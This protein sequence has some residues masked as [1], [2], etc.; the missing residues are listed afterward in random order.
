MSKLKPK[1]VNQTA[2]LNL[3]HGS[4]ILYKK[5]FIQ[6]HL[7]SE[8]GTIFR[9]L[10]DETKFE[11]KD[12]VVLGKKVKQPRLLAYYATD[13][14]RGSFTYTGLR[15]IPSH[16]TPFVEQLKNSVQEYVKE[17]FDS[18]LLNY[19]RDGSDTVGWHADNEKL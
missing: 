5:K 13:I 4:F 3:G 11:Q 7:A 9:Q 17:E 18:V 15:N 12:L 2:D 6:P 16:F 19:Y 1:E 10:M 8:T 14:E